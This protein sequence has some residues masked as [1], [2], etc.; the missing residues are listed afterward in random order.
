MKIVKI[1]IL[2]MAVILILSG[3]GAQNS[4]IDTYLGNNDNKNC[5]VEETSLPTNEEI[6][7][8][9]HLVEKWRF[10]I[11]DVAIH[12]KVLTE[13]VYSEVVEVFGEPMEIKTYRIPDLSAGEDEY[14]YFNVAAYDGIEI[15]FIA[16]TDTQNKIENTEKVFRFDLVN[17]N[18]TMRCGL[19]VGM[20]LDEFQI[21][22]GS[23]EI[24]DINSKDETSQLNDIKKLL[25]DYK[26]KGY[27]SEYTQAIIIYSDPDRTENVTLA[28]AM[29]LLIKD[30]QVDRIVLGYPTAD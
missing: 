19:K 9:K 30:N 23:R 17:S 20:T 2:Q 15:E 14:R 7:I 24:C 8:D 5:V 28:I 13:M 25:E 21:K 16:E 4:N 6:D 3:C 26:P 27:F 10:G 18:F 1:I 11:T 29:V 12:D 22:F